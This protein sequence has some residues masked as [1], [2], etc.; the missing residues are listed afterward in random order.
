MSG[1]SFLI[2]YLLRK[3]LSVFGLPSGAPSRLRVAWRVLAPLAAALWGL[4]VPSA[5]WAWRPPV[6]EVLGRA[7]VTVTI[8]AALCWFAGVLSADGRRDLIR[9]NADLYR[10]I[11]EDERP[12]TLQQVASGR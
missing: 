2:H 9:Q 10:R 6:M 3:S 1:F 4:T 8:V 11:P 5:W 7:A 12:P